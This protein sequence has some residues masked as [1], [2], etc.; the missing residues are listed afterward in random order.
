MDPFT[1][2][3]SPLPGQRSLGSEGGATVTPVERPHVWTV[4]PEEES[5]DRRRL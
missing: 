5:G 4:A 3:G 2:F 1:N